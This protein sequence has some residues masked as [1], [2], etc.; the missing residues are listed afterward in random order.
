MLL[1][2]L[3]AATL[4]ALSR[5]GYAGDEAHFAASFNKTQDEIMLTLLHWEKAD[6]AIRWMSGYLSREAFLD[7]LNDLAAFARRDGYLDFGGRAGMMFACRYFGREQEARQ[8]LEELLAT[9][10]G[11]QLDWI[12][13]YAG[14]GWRSVVATPPGKA[15]P[16]VAR[17]TICAEARAAYNRSCR[18]TWL[19][20]VVMA[21]GLPLLRWLVC[22]GDFS[23]LH[24]FRIP[25]A[26]RSTGTLAAWLRA[27][28][29]FLFGSVGL[30]TILSLTY[31]IDASSLTQAQW[32]WLFRAGG[33]LQTG[34]RALWDSNLHNVLYAALMTGP[35]F[36]LARWQTP[37]FHATLRMFGVRR[38][39]LKARDLSRAIAAGLALA[40][41]LYIGFELIGEVTGM[42]DPRD[43]WSRSGA[44]LWEQVLFGC[45]VAPFAE[46]F[47][48]RG[49]LFTGISNSRGVIASAV[50]SSVFFAATHG[51]S[52]TGTLDITGFGLLMCWLYRRTGTLLVPM[53]VHSLTN[54]LLLFY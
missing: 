37:G 8:W 54:A 20:L 52:L 34:Y 53:G 18:P 1:A 29:I 27:E 7:D 38:C 23:R 22:R 6:P 3:T 46:E 17:R 50:I 16:V 35:V 25:D 45:V 51:Y 12:P 41:L 4:W 26:W 28:W 24:R 47:I 9:T 19:V 43:G 42:S 5:F 48:F 14:S 31:A 32:P 39:P 40:T 15:D 33:W 13:E 36:L 49:F 2:I 30:T 44:P 10:P 21:A 11:D